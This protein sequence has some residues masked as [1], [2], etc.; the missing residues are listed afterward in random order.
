[1]LYTLIE[2]RYIF[3]CVSVMS[4]GG[5][6]CAKTALLV[7]EGNTIDFN[8]LGFGSKFNTLSIKI[9]SKDNYLRKRPCP[10]V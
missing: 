1:M 5:V 2:I 8:G 7:C 3:I 9:I 6:A 4:F 10:G